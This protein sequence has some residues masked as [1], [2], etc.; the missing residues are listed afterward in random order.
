[1]PKFFEFA[2][3]RG[4]LATLV[5]LLAKGEAA[6]FLDFPV[7]GGWSLRRGTS[8][9]VRL[10]RSRPCKDALGALAPAP[11]LVVFRVEWV[12]GPAFGFRQFNS[13]NEFQP[14]ACDCRRGCLADEGLQSKCTVSVMVTLSDDR[15]YHP[16]SYIDCLRDIRGHKASVG[17]PQ[18][19][20]RTTLTIF[21]GLEDGLRNGDDDGG[22]KMARCN[23][24]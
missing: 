21:D 15:T 19:W 16:A 2:S 3:K 23:G 22:W 13:L 7:L 18:R 12:A 1:M 17:S 6:G 9:S 20:Q 11:L 8:A 14:E 4:F 24:A 10:R 5:L